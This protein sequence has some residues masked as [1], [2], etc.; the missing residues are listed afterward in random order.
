M[1]DETI[2]VETSTRATR[3]ARLLGFAGLFPFVGLSLWLLGIAPD[4]E[5]RAG[6][7]LLLLAYGA[8]I[9]S[10]LGG[11][12][13]GLALAREQADEP[14]DYVLSM[15][16]PLIGWLAVIIPV[17]YAFALLAVAFAAQ[18]AWDALAVHTGRAPAWYGR[19]RTILTMVVVGC[20]IVAFIATS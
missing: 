17:P 9:L 1:L 16:P 20:M 7:I 15:A 13:W 6:T 3:I 4:H 11:A 5:W 19:L 12:R 18:G 8:V 2:D 10:F 14:L